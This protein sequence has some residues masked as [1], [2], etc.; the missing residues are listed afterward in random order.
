MSAP[1][2]VAPLAAHIA[3]RMKRTRSSNSGLPEENLLNGKESVKGRCCHFLFF[4]F[5]FFFLEG[6]REDLAGQEPCFVA[7]VVSTRVVSSD[8]QTPLMPGLGP[9]NGSLLQGFIYT[10]WRRASD[11]ERGTQR[12]VTRK[13]RGI[14][15]K[16]PTG[17]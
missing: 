14:R 2:L 10:S 4:L 11:R 13:C 3:Q 15:P 16:L 5:F 9:K 12:E 8:F 6:K 1:G 7:Y 17:S